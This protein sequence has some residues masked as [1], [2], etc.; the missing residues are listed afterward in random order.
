M[1]ISKEKM[2]KLINI[3]RS[4][5]YI[6]KNND[7]IMYTKS[8]TLRLGLFLTNEI[9]DRIDHIEFMNKCLED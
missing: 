1:R 6:D 4:E 7:L 2:L 5:Q 3:I 8:F 9:D